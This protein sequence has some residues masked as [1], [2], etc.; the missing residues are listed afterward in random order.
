M[1]PL[2]LLDVDGVINA[3]ASHVVKARHKHPDGQ[4]LSKR[5]FPP[6]F[7]HGL[8]VIWD[9]RVTRFIR[10][11]SSEVDVMW[12]TT[13][14][15]LAPTLLAPAIGLP[16]FPVL[17]AQDDVILSPKTWWKLPLAQRASLDRDIIWTD[18]DLQFET[19]ARE[20]LSGFP[21]RQL[22]IAPDYKRG[23]TPEHLDRIREFV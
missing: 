14:V 16:D 4:W 15:D 18:D 1:K 21:G 5:L 7:D 11:I 17:G 20:W 13:W 9:A 10:D 8:V 2:W 12:L 19:P 6:G 3:L 22:A 23:L